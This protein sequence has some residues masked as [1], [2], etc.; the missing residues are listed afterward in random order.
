MGSL[1]HSV[2]FYGNSQDLLLKED[3]WWCQEAKTS[4]SGNGRGMHESRIWDS[5]GVLVASTWQDGLVRKSKNEDGQK[6][7][8]GWLK[9]SE[10]FR[11]AGKAVGGPEKHKL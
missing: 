3:D 8:L 2:V 1:S 10:E 6:Q 9:W 11:M 4:R 7:R 5:K